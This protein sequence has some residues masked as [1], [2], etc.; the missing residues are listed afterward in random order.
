MTPAD[1][2]AARI[3]ADLQFAIEMK[4]LFGELR[5]EKEV[6]IGDHDTLMISG[7]RAGLPPV[8]MYFDKQSGLLIRMVRYAQ[9]P[10][11]RNPTQI[12][13]SDYRNVAGV[14]LPFQ[15]VSSTPTGRF[16]IHLESAQPN[17]SIPESRFEKPASAQQ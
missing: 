2:E 6:N 5:V 10:L 4:K 13:Y 12:D 11:G 9:S 17:V 14:K 1:V 16:T 8:E 7:Q 15:W 3:D